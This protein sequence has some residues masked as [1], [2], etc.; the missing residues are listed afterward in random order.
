MRIGR[1]IAALIRASNGTKKDE[2]SWRDCRQAPVNVYAAGAAGNLGLEL[3]IW[4]E[5]LVVQGV[6]V[7][8]LAQI[9]AFASNR[10]MDELRV[11][12][13][14]GHPEY[15]I[16]NKCEQL[17]LQLQFDGLEEESICC[18]YSERV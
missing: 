1:S 18:H 13:P 3:M 14:P 17:F 9:N 10:D 11:L 2:E 6:H 12:C 16:R 15:R 8:H 7:N 5:R 4:R